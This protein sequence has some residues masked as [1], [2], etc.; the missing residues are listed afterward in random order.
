[1]F[2]RRLSIAVSC[3]RYAF[4]FECFTLLQ[5]PPRSSD[6]QAWPCYHGKQLVG[7]ISFLEPTSLIPDILL[8]VS[9]RMLREVYPP[10]GALSL[11][12]APT[13]E[14]WS[15]STKAIINKQEQK[16]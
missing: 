2:G 10:A 13:G 9:G 15:L 11:T 5:T 3:I 4:A 12:S 14:C 16:P 8:W 1:M 6:I 7:G